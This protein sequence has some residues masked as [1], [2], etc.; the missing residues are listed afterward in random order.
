MEPIWLFQ[1]A[2][3]IT[4]PLGYLRIVTIAFMSFKDDSFSLRKN[5]E[6]MK[7]LGWVVRIKQIDIHLQDI[8]Y[9]YFF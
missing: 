1:D 2:Q 4:W 9:H 3:N 8:V 5:D 6:Q 7:D